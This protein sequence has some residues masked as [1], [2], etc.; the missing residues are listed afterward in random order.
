MDEPTALMPPVTTRSLDE[1]LHERGAL[2][3]HEAVLL[4]HAVAQALVKVIEQKGASAPLVLEHIRVSGFEQHL[5]VVIL[6][7][8]EGTVDLSSGS[9]VFS[10]GVVAFT[11]LVGRPPRLDETLAD[12]MPTVPAGVDRVVSRLLARERDQRPAAAQAVQ[13]FEELLHALGEPSVRPA[14]V[15]APPPQI[16][17]GPAIGELRTDAKAW[18]IDPEGTLRVKAHDAGEGPTRDIRGRAPTSGDGP[19]RDN[20]FSDDEATATVQGPLAG[21]SEGDSEER[22]ALDPSQDLSATYRRPGFRTGDRAPL[23]PPVP[24]TEPPTGDHSTVSA[25]ARAAG[26]EDVPFE[27]T[28]GDVIGAPAPAHPDHR[29]L[30]RRRP[31][32]KPATPVEQLMAF[33]QKQPPWIWGVLGVGLAFFVLLLIALSR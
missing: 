11:L 8:G 26:R 15:L 18:A 6:T 12:A 5:P 33:A 29:E 9:D 1:I 19:T 28:K 24:M 16:K 21:D 10:L 30:V 13:L 27:A 2:T 32:K 31:P 14:S 23:A 4:L 25:R 3:P 22:T 17:R 20:P 7:E